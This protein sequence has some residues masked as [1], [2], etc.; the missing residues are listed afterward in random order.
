MILGLLFG[1]LAVGA[2]AGVCY[3]VIEDDLRRHRHRILT[4]PP[5]DEQDEA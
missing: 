5:P 3:F 1:I 2:M 4:W